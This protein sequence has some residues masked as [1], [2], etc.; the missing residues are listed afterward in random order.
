MLMR[1]DRLLVRKQHIG[2]K[3]SMAD[4]VRLDAIGMHTHD[5]YAPHSHEVRSDHLGVYREHTTRLSGIADCQRERNDQAMTHDY[6]VDL[7]HG[8]PAKQSYATATPLRQL[9]REGKTGQPGTYARNR[10]AN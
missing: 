4:E 7:M 9:R 10:L 3:N 1:P 6:P 5:G 2:V 8:E